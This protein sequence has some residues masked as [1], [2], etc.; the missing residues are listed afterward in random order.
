MTYAVRIERT[1]GSPI[2]VVRRRAPSHRLSAVV[3]EACGTVWSALKA[4]NVKGAGRHVAVYL[5]CA[6]EQIDV[7]IGAEIPGGSAL[8]AHSEVFGSATPAGD[9]ATVTHLGPYGRLGDA[10]RAIRDWCAANHRPLAGPNW[11]IYG[12]W[13][14]AW[15]EDPSQIRTD[16]FYLLR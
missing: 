11:E 16:V 4:M 13:D 12:H 10:H 8:P 5:N 9:A 14:Q 3:P 1:P 6:D 15:N 7:E 2:A